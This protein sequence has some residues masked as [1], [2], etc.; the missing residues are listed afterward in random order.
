MQTVRIFVGGEWLA[1]SP[2]NWYEL[3]NP[4]TGEPLGRVPM[5]GT[6]EVSEAVGAAREAFPKWR[7]TPVVQRARY[8]FK[9]RTLLEEN[10]DE[11]ARLVAQG[12]GKTMDEARGSR[13]RR[14]DN[15]EHAGCVPRRM[16]G[17]S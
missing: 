2:S 9:F 14:V 1:P 12:T 15:V 6:T 7:E 10:F 3:T 13:R 4:A 8:L 16:L 11:I 5:C 17:D